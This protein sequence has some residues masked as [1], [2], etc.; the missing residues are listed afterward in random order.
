MKVAVIGGGVAGSGVAIYLQNLGIDVTLFEKK[1]SIVNGPPM[2]HLHAGRNLYPEISDAQCLQLLEESIELLRFY[3]ES[4]DFRPTIVA[5]QK[6]V[7]VSLD[8]ILNRLEKLKSR[9]AELISKDKNNK[10]LGEIDEYYKIYNKKDILKLKN[11]EYKKPESLDDWMIPFAK[12]VDIESIKWP[13]IL[14]QEYGL[15]VFR[16]AA[17]ATMLLDKNLK[18][19]TEV[20]NIEKLDDGFLIT[21]KENGEIKKEKFDY[22]INAA[23]FETGIFD[24]MINEKKERFTEFKAAY[25]V[26]WREDIV[27]PEVV[28]LGERGTPKGMGQFTPYANGY[29]QLHGMTKEITL[30]DDGLVKT[31]NSSY[32]KLPTHFIEKIE[33][34][35]DKE[36][37]RSNKAIKHLQKFIPSFE[38]KSGYKPLYGAQQI[39][40]D[41]PDLRA[42]EVSFGD[43]YAR[44][45][46]VK[47]SSIFAMAREIQKELQ[48]LGAKPT[49][50]ENKTL[51]PL[52]VDK[53][54]M[55]IAESRNYP[56]EMGL[57]VN[58]KPL[59]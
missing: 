11:K 57:V 44:C 41:D 43:R 27:W 46:I 51:N 30:F 22:L 9:Y 23:G 8:K 13:V 48:K 45:E 42:A 59:L 40:G 31:K 34:G 18:L 19:N 28:F 35:W 55:K 14:V 38:A 32:P 26:K 58:K 39:P 29:F 3:P 1:D 16:I 56:K 37:T 24:D 47:A 10:V 2:C 50:K 54:A 36:I 20:T 25:V 21:Y 7:D 17:S 15:N 53:L 49:K 6:D 5:V 52:E 12:N 33:K 4:I